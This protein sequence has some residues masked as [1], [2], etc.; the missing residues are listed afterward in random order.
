MARVLVAEELRYFAR[1]I[2]P[3]HDIAIE[4]LPAAAPTPGGPYRGLLPLLSRTVDAEVLDHLPELRVIANCAVGYDNIDLTAARA[5]GVAVSN[6][7]DVLTEATADLTWALILAVCRRLRE[8]ERL[9]RS[10]AWEGWHPAQLLGLELQGRCLG[11]LGAGR[12]GRAVGRR[13]RGFGMEVAYWS[14]SARPDWEAEVGARREADLAD[15]LGRADI[16][17]VHLPLTDETT[18]LLG[19][20]ELRSMKPGGVLVNTARGG[21]VDEDALC[22]VLESGHLWGAGLD[23][24]DGEPEIDSRL[25]ALERAVLLPHLGSAT[26]TTRRRMFEVAWENL[27]RGVRGEP[28]LNPVV[29]D[30]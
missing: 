8:A 22:D 10:G 4:W 16:V 23:V 30:R 2:E 7:P 9:L 26:E 24:F 27:E 17:S 28:L 21:I 13:A 15:L 6:T 20:D 29:G 25:L 19:G 18:G 12:I 5:R 11:V 3:S 1:F 14:R